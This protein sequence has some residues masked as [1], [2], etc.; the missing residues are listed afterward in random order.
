MLTVVSDETITAEYSVCVNGGLVGYTADVKGVARVGTDDTLGG[1]HEHWDACQDEVLTATCV[2][3]PLHSSR[4]SL[5]GMGSFSPT[6]HH[7]WVSISVLCIRSKLCITS[8][9]VKIS[10]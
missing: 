4:G 5:S 1:K 8:W 10:N 2:P 9:K 7:A 6:G 3:W